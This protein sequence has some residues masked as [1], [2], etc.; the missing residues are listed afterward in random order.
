MSRKASE[1][2]LTLGDPARL[3]SASATLKDFLEQL[4]L[5]W[6]DKER[7]SKFAPPHAVSLRLQGSDPVAVAAVVDEMLDALL[8]PACRRTQVLSIDLGT[9]GGREAPSVGSEIARGARR[10]R[11]ALTALNDVKG[12]DPE[13]LLQGPQG[14][15]TRRRGVRPHDAS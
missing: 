12:V 5:N 13:Q 8:G 11:P 10:R 7:S 3:S 1:L 14:A 9:T 4:T 15:Q 6:T 2:G